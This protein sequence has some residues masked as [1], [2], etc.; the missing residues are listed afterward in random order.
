MNQ[1][2][3]HRGPDG[4]GVFIDGSLGLGHRRLAI[5]DLT[6]TGRQPMSY[7]DG[8]YWITYNGEIF[9]FIELRDELESFGYS[10][11]SDTDTEVIL[12][13]YMH[14]GECCQLKFNGMWAFAI[15]DKVKKTLFVS[16]DR[17]A[18]KPLYYIYDGQHFAFA[19]EMKGFLALEWF[20]AVFDNTSVAS[21]L[22]RTNDFEGTE[23]CLLHGVRRLQAGFCLTV[24][25]GKVPMLKRWWNTLEHLDSVPNEFDQQVEKFRALFFDA[26]RIRMRSDVPI[27]TALSGGMDSSSVLCTMNHMRRTGCG[28]RR[29]AA[30]WQHAFVATFPGT[31]QDERQ[32]AEEVVRATGVKSTY[33]RMSADDALTYLDDALFDFEEIDLLPTPV[34]SLYRQMRASNVVVSL[35]GHGADEMLAGYYWY[36]DIG[37]REGLAEYLRSY[38]SVDSDAALERVRNLE[39]VVAGLRLEDLG[40]PVPRAR[41]ILSELLGKTHGPKKTAGSTSSGWLREKPRPVF[42]ANYKQDVNMMPGFD[43]ICKRM[44]LDFHYRTL[45][46]ILRNFDRCSMSNGVEV[47]APFMDWRLVCY[48]FALS[49]ETKVRNGFTKYILRQ[50]MKELLPKSIRLR[51]NKLGFVSPLMDW[52]QGSMKP[53]IL[54]AVN[55]SDFLQSS[56]WN[57]HVIRDSVE[58]AYSQNDFKV[59]THAWNYI[60]AM[61]I[62]QLFRQRGGGRLPLPE[63]QHDV[64][65]RIRSPLVTNV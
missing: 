22:A 52:V 56:V 24:R 37:M 21:Q 51:K 42:F 58:K 13:A 53:Y 11:R 30:D 3:V 61:R 9:N 55:S 50:A 16:R 40:V 1:F 38:P 10:F 63:S 39:Q 54:D 25:F 28:Q 12:A 6:E 19:S 57:G 64:E 20:D 31:G 44:Y 35:D 43:G 59:V 2:L 62:M 33:A 46:T 26:C 15:W 23:H 45:P 36:P 41:Q 17:F 14:W 29:L 27:G 5:L 18:I 48:V 60:Q 8:R 7:A 49:T 32:Y 4:E 47:R 65:C 34:W